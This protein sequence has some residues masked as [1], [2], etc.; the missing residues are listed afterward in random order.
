M[1]SGNE[2]TS[3]ITY[4]EV[5]Y[6]ARCPGPSRV[7]IHTQGRVKWKWWQADWR[8]HTSEYSILMHMRR[9]VAVLYQNIPVLTRHRPVDPVGQIPESSRICMCLHVWHLH[10]FNR[11]SR[12]WN[13]VLTRSLCEWSWQNSIVM[14]WPG[15]TWLHTCTLHVCAMR[16][17]V[18]ISGLKLCVCVCIIHTGC[19]A[20]RVI[21]L[22][23]MLYV[24]TTPSMAAITLDCKGE[25]PTRLCVCGFECVCVCVWGG[26]IAMC[27]GG[28][29][30]GAGEE[31]G[32][33]VIYQPD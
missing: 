14:S 18:Q 29:R 26:G 27:L 17:C 25:P 15:D 5:D 6:T 24:T 7:T 8:E 31:R 2:H 9:R 28:L 13:D 32:R 30:E 10:V 23:G 33:G 1:P 4:R 21:R 12:Q 3:A 11:A 22:I 16:I 19:S 20:S